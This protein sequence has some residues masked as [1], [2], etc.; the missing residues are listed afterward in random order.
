MIPGVA[1]L[2]DITGGVAE[3]DEVA[4]F[5]IVNGGSLTN[6]NGDVFFVNNTRAVITLFSYLLISSRSKYTLYILETKVLGMKL[7]QKSS[8]FNKITSQTEHSLQRECIILQDTLYK[9]T[10]IRR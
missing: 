8:A 3:D 9:R 6:T 10:E 4:V 7:L 2:T 5:E 1:E